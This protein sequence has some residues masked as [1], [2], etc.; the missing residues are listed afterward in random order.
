MTK[1]NA[2]QDRHNIK[3]MRNTF[4]TK[5]MLRNVNLSLLLVDMAAQRRASESI[6]VISC[7]LR[8][9]CS[10]S[11]WKPGQQRRE[12]DLCEPRRVSRQEER[13]G[14]KNGKRS[15]FPLKTSATIA[16]RM[17]RDGGDRLRFIKVV[18]ADW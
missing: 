5:S 9:T 8:A 17:V 3:F 4:L 16:L 6:A 11:P 2:P 13:F 7:I 1:R 18:L 14:R 10:K 15:S 12:S